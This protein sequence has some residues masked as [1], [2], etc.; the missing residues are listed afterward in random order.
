MRLAKT[1]SGLRVQALNLWRS[2]V[3]NMGKVPRYQEGTWEVSVVRAERWTTPRGNCRQLITGE[4][5]A[6]DGKQLPRRSTLGCG[7]PGHRGQYF[8]QSS[9]QVLEEVCPLRN[10]S[11]TRRARFLSFATAFNRA[12]HVLFYSLLPPR[13]LWLIRAVCDRIIDK[14]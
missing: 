5:R 13:G 2:A 1:P 6:G 12:A 10:T 7:G 8:V 9:Q 11:P 3:F 4:V 14:P